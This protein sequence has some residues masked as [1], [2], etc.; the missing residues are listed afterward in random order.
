MYTRQS[1]KVGGISSIHHSWHCSC[2]TYFCCFPLTLA[3]IRAFLWRTV[4]SKPSTIPSGIVASTFSDKL[5]RNSFI[6]NHLPAECSNPKSPGTFR[7]SWIWTMKLGD[8]KQISIDRKILKEFSPMNN[9]MQRLT[10]RVAQCKICL[11]RFVQIDGLLCLRF[12][13]PNNWIL[14]KVNDRLI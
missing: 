3:N 14:L 13:N 9:P 6:C 12:I 7:L 8:V 1:R 10:R 5:S 11:Y 4:N 2:G